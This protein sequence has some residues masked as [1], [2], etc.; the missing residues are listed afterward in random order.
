MMG[1]YVAE[2]EANTKLA[3]TLTAVLTDG[4]HELSPDAQAEADTLLSMTPEE[5]ALAMG[6]I[7][8]VTHPEIMDLL[9]RALERDA[10]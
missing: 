4:R 2:R 5:L 10:R 3:T 9:K 1:S 7:G 6:H 8:I